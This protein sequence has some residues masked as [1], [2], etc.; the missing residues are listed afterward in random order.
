MA[1]GGPGVVARG[2]WRGAVVAAGTARGGDGHAGENA[3]GRH[4]VRLENKE[5]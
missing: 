1:V 3:G 2:L 5:A 4:S